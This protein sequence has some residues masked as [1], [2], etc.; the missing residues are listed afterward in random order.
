MEE[1]HH[2]AEAAPKL[3]APDL[4]RMVNRESDLCWHTT[5]M[6]CDDG[7]PNGGGAK[8]GV[9]LISGVVRPHHYSLECPK[10]DCACAIRTND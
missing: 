1:Y 9:E 2:H 7:N 8:K 6:E 3:A 10:W 5:H 4:L